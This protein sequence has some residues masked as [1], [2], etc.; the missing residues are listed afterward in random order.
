[1]STYEALSLMLAFGVLVAIIVSDKKQL[2]L[3]TQKP[4]IDGRR[5]LSNMIRGSRHTASA[6]SAFIIAL[7]FKYATSYM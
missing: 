7:I 1:M 3:L 6:I 4:P 2:R 5:F